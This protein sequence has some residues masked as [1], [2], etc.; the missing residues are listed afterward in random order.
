MKQ[1]QRENIRVQVAGVVGWGKNANLHPK[2]AS[3]GLISD[4]ERESLSSD[5]LS[6]S[7]TLVMT[8]LV[9]PTF[10]ARFISFG[11]V[12]VRRYLLGYPVPRH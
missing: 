11:V 7:V 6:E 8:C 2:S 9:C 10:C 4:S 1:R 3:Y 12:S 5:T